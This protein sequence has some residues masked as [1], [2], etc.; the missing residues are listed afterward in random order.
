MFMCRWPNGSLSFVFAAKEDDAICQLDELGNAE[1]AEL[2]RI[3]H[4]MIDLELT[5]KGD[6]KSPEF[7]EETSAVV[8]ERAFPYVGA[9]REEASIDKNLNL[10]PEGEDLMRKAVSKEKSR[11]LRIKSRKGVETELGKGT[12]FRLL[13]PLQQA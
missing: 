13:L 4:F 6:L 8:W 2:T 10:T 3:K 12:V 5:E 9:A 1:L 11:P 7:G